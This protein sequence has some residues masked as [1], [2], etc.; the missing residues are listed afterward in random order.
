MLERYWC[1]GFFGSKNSKIFGSMDVH[2][3]YIQKVDVYESNCSR[4]FTSWMYMKKNGCA[5]KSQKGAS[6]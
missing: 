2:N 3:F 1:H 4:T 6:A 5:R